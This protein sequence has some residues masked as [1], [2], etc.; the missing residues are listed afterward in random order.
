MPHP[1]QTFQ[2]FSM[3]L[4]HFGHRRLNGLALPQNGQATAS[5]G[6]SSPQ[7]M[8]C[9]LYVA[10]DTPPVYNHTKLYHGNRF[11]NNGLIADFYG[12]RVSC[13]TVR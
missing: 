10:M 13:A 11:S 4:R 2:P 5:P 12:S 3:G 6:I 8:Q 1:L 7:W 9:F